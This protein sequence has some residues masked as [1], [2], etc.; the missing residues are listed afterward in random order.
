MRF[1]KLHTL[2]LESSSIEDIDDQYFDYYRSGATGKLRYLIH[3]YALEK[4]FN[5]HSAYHTSKTGTYHRNKPS[6]NIFNTFDIGEAEETLWK[7]D[8][9]ISVMYPAWFTNDEEY[10][11]KIG[12]N[13]K[14]RQFKLSIQNPFDLR[15][16]GAEFITG[17]GIIE[18]RKD[19]NLPPIIDI[20]K[21]FSRPAYDLPK[22]GGW[23]GIG[24]VKAGYD[25]VIVSEADSI[26]YVVYN[27]NQIKLYDSV[28]LDDEGEVIPLSQRFDITSPDIR[29]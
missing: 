15:K 9:K 17:D 1:E 11:R 25:G 13:G 24:I 18:I 20:D 4:G 27:P 2:C 8:K 14:Q 7:S 12:I 26:S 16:Y 22:A 5:I 19:L 6:T 10:G 28:T 29:Y 23:L 3:K 21:S